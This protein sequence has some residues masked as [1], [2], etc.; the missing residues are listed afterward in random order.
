MVTEH[1]RMAMVTEH[2]RMVTEHGMVCG[3]MAKSR[4]GSTI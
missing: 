4:E 1:V 3:F 2:V